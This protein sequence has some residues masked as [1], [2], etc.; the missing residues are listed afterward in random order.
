[1][2]RRVSLWSEAIPPN[3]KA[4]SNVTITANGDITKL[5][6]S[7]L[8]YQ[9]PTHSAIGTLPAPGSPTLKLGVKSGQLDASIVPT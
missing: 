7:G 5:L 4:I 8:H 6:S 9:K 3:F 2:A 1:M